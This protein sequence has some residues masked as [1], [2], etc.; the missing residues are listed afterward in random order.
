V[1]RL[2]RAVVFLL[3]VLFMLPM[4]SA[5][6]VSPV[7]SAGGANGCQPGGLFGQV[8]PQGNALV[9]ILYID[10]ESGNACVLN[11]GATI[12]GD[13]I[14]VWLYTPVTPPNGTVPIGVE[15][16][17]WVQRADI[18]PGP[19][20]TTRSIEVATRADVEWSNA[21]VPA[22]ARAFEQFDLNVPPVFVAPSDAANLTLTI[23]GLTLQYRIATPGTAVP[24]PLTLGTFIGWLAIMSPA[25]VVS[26]VGGFGPA[27]VVT[28]RLRYVS[29]GRWAALL[30]LLVT[31]GIALGILA[32]FTGFEYW[33]GGAGI[34][35]LA[36]LLLFPMFLWG[37]ALWI[38]VRGSHLQSR[39]IRAPIAKSQKGE[40]VVGAT[41]IKVY[42]GGDTGHEEELVEGLGIGGVSA[43]WHRFLGLRVRWRADAIA[44]EPVLIHYDW[45]RGKLDI[46]GEYAAWPTGN[47]HAIDY[48]VRRE[49]VVYFPWRKS[50]RAKYDPLPE[51]AVPAG[52]GAPV[53]PPVEG[54]RDPS[55]WAHRGFL[56]GLRHGEAKISAL[57]KPDYLGPDQYVRGLAPARSFALESQQRGRVLTLVYERISAEAEELAHKMVAIRNR[58]KEFP[59]SPEAMEGLRE[60]S[61]RM[62]G[63][64]FDEEKYL[65]R[66]EERGRA[67]VDYRP[68]GAKEYSVETRVQTEAHEALPPD[69][70]GRGPRRS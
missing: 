14:Q 3:G 36:V 67:R 59:G 11:Q 43:A 6:T 32:D 9:G 33:L 22:A 39:L 56:I 69:M 4:A 64:L 41:A 34:A 50:I 27:E 19:N 52:A 49:E 46:E 23:L 18:V 58:V 51:E 61:G 70:R 57:G 65:K 55:L 48:T 53:P 37:S 10:P 15:E 45:S 12:P 29:T 38:S 2:V 42:G 25:A 8:A 60:L 44:R 17:R 66:L 31:L 62:V 30:A 26:F 1:R 21:S 35:G 40:P 24:V 16:F 28:R 13:V 63:I 47:G 7:G 5:S 20:N 54:A 68:P